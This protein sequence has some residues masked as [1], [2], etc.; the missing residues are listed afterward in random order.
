MRHILSGIRGEICSGVSKKVSVRLAK[1]ISFF[2]NLLSD[3]KGLPPDPAEAPNAEAVFASAE[4]ADLRQEAE[5][6]S[7]CHWLRA[8]TKLDIP[9]S[10]R[11]LLPTHL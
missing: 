8:F 9:P 5:M 11:G 3:K 6:T 2:E 10:F 7:V 4:F 1:A